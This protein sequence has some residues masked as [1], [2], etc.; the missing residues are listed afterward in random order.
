MSVAT[1]YD[2]I[3]E[4]HKF[5]N[6]VGCEEFRAKA[7]IRYWLKVKTGIED[8]KFRIFDHTQKNKLT[9]PNKDVFGNDLVPAIAQHSNEVILWY[10]YKYDAVAITPYWFGSVYYEKEK[11]E[12]DEGL[13]EEELNHN[14]FKY[15]YSTKRH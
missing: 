11:D 3:L 10:D 15:Y 6:V 12:K 2:S 8:T 4:S 14:Y 7:L 1:S 5:P 9:R 13:T